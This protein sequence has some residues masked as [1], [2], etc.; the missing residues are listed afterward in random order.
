MTALGYDT[1]I[2]EEGEKQYKKGQAKIQEEKRRQLQA[3]VMWS[4]SYWK[5]VI[6]M[7]LESRHFKM[8]D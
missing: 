1:F 6:D 4:Y 7:F 3:K 5:I 8:N 2:T